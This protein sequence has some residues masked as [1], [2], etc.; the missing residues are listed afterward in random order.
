MR[1]T[2]S[3]HPALAAR[4]NSLMVQSYSVT[5]PRVGRKGTALS[6]YWDTAY[7]PN[8]TL[9]I[10]RWQHLPRGPRV[11]QMVLSYAPQN[12]VIFKG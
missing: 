11:K 1:D 5:I 9:F 3:F 8:E 12:Y 6:Q 10:G 4:Q 2:R 7:L